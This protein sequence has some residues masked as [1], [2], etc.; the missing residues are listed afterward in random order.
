[1]PPTP[2]KPPH[3]AARHKTNP[4]AR[5]TPT[6]TTGQLTQ[7]VLPPTLGTIS[8]KEKKEKKEKLKQ[9]VT[10]PIVQV[11]EPMN[12]TQI[13]TQASD[14]DIT[15]S[16]NEKRRLKK[17]RR[18]DKRSKSLGGEVGSQPS[19]A[20]EPALASQEEDKVLL[21]QNPTTPDGKE[22][23]V[24]QRLMSIRAPSPPS[25]T[26]TPLKK[27]STT[28][29]VQAEKV[30]PLPALAANNKASPSK[31]DKEK[32]HLRA[33]KAQKELARA[34]EEAKKREEV[35]LQ[36]EKA[37]E[38][39]TKAKEEAQRVKEEAEKKEE[40][41]KKRLAE[42]EE[43]VKEGKKEH[44]TQ[45]TIITEHEKT[46]RDL[47]E[48][49]IC[50][51][52]FEIFNDPHILSCG[53]VACKGCLQS[54]FR[55]PSA[56]VHEP[57]EEITNDTDLSHR[58]KECHAC[59]ARVL[60]RPARVFL[61]RTIIEP[62]GLKANFP[63]G[64][65]D[66]VDPW[67]N[68]FPIEQ[69][70]YRL[71]DEQD[72]IWRC[73]SCTA[74]IVGGICEG[75]SLEF[76]DVEDDDA[77]DWSEDDEV[78]S[79]LEGL[80]LGDGGEGLELA[81]GNSDDTDSDSHGPERTGRANTSGRRTRDGS[82]NDVDG[83]VGGNRQRHV[84]RGT[85]AVLNAFLFDDEASDDG[86]E[87][88]EDHERSLSQIG[89]EESYEDSFIDDGSV[90]E[91]DDGM[92]VPMGSGSEDE[93]QGSDENAEDELQVDERESRSHRH[94]GGLPPRVRRQVS[95]EEDSPVVVRRLSRR[96]R[97]VPDS[98]SE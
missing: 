48:A 36:L 11:D 2:T 64:S 80:G 23:E 3:K 33:I 81:G 46:R 96:T 89:S 22:N 87:G 50:P 19:P 27:D 78:G 9:E 7:G 67:N 17:K 35:R 98:D 49:V 82:A 18:K 15:S 25:L 75:C 69:E 31:A 63:S 61:I 97:Q 32:Q 62:L 29:V 20:L 95:E 92:D 21:P 66:Q 71:Y 68:I 79:V 65:Q 8:K 77:E 70:T 86:E 55:T 90:H 45:Q 10:E 4:Y 60:R 37:H 84:A 14:G 38:E 12:G 74:E 13:S 85:E 59:R 73:P 54:W 5:P 34:R 53:H 1:M 39:V 88:S 6:S 58:S 52:C 41:M 16:Q 47:I 56:Y 57:L 94:R 26:A 43:A 76:S 42:L 44:D 28:N 91:E 24:F 51:V 40:E 30:T 72:S 83:A 93:G